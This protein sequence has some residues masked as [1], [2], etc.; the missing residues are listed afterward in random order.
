[1]S[2]G[3]DELSRELARPTSRRGV[4]KMIG[5]AA[6]AATAATLVRPFRAEAACPSGAPVCGTG[7]CAAGETCTDPSSGCCCASGT[8]PCGPACCKSG[9]ACVDAAS[10]ICG[11]P[12]GYTSCGRGSNLTCC[13]AGKACGSTSC[14]PASNL[15]SKSTAK[16]CGGRACGTTCW[17]CGGDFNASLCGSSGPFHY[18]LCGTPTEGGPCFCFGSFQCGD[19]GT[20]SAST[21]CPT[22]FKC[23]PTCCGNQCAPPCGTYP[24]AAANVAGSGGDPSKAS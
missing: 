9:I 5:G 1:M 15:S 20:C 11:C 21:D 2:H 18:C 17:T 4:L 14:V 3:F 22:G 12:A 23:I 8:T 19:F 16:Q 24:V 6:A 7:C 10:G 13:P